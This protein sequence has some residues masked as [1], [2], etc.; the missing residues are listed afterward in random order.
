MH[1]SKVMSL[2][3]MKI[4]GQHGRE[5]GVITDMFADVETW[6][7]Q[8]LEVTLNRETLD[9]LKLKRPWFGT[10]TVHVP[11]SEISGATDNLVLESILEEMDFSGGQPAAAAP[12]AEKG[13]S[14]RTDTPDDGSKS[15][16]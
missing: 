8:S 12:L 1:Q 13:E 15:T 5:V 10:Q 16:N 7:L 2:V 6:H 4:I 9:D 3:G 14:E 11:V